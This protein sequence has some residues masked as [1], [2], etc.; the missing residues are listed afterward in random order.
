MAPVIVAK[1]SELVRRCP[2]KNWKCEAATLHAFVR[3]NVRYQQ[4]I[5]DVETLRTPE[6]TLEMGAGDCDDMCILLASLLQAVGHPVRFVAVSFAPDQEYSHV[7]LETKIGNDWW[8]AE[9][10]E[11]WPFGSAPPGVVRDLTVF[12]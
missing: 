8:P 11:P 7:F 6:L 10:T 1:A 5:A 3:D 4:D 12:V 2:P 9:C